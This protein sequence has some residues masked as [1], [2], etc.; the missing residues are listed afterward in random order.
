[1]H[2]IFVDSNWLRRRLRIRP[3]ASSRKQLLN[4]IVSKWCNAQWLKLNGLAVTKLMA[5]SREVSAG[6]G[7]TCR[8]FRSEKTC[9][10]SVVRRDGNTNC[11]PEY[12][13]LA[14]HLHVGPAI[15]ES[16]EMVTLA[17]VSKLKVSELKDELNKLGLP[18]AGLKKTL[19]ARLTEALEVRN[20]KSISLFLRMKSSCLLMFQALTLFLTNDTA[21]SL[22]MITTCV[23]RQPPRQM[24][25]S[26]MR[27]R[28][29]PHLLPRPMQQIPPSKQL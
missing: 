1:M 6:W 9:N 23:L 19:A 12:A 25:Q 8:K 3:Y 11:I 21:D 16:G 18:L 22:L 17:E 29:R 2:S 4:A 26:P 7:R 14:H 28:M 15:A 10:V 24:M 27:P 13:F 5:I 20:L